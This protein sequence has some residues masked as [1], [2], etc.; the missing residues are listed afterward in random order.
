MNRVPYNNIETSSL[1]IDCLYEDSREPGSPIN[2][3]PLLRIFPGI[4][5]MKG[6]RVIGNTPSWKLFVL[7]STEIESDWPDALDE[8]SG[9]LT[10]WG[11]FVF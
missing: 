3:Q 2:G 10:Y 5:N 4:G 6:I 1:V 11:F 7:T 8:A 9:I